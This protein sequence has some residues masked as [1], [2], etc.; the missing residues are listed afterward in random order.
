[1]KKRLPIE[2]TEQLDDASLAELEKATPPVFVNF[3]N[4]DDDQESADADDRSRKEH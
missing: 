1:M 2:K 4:D 3:D